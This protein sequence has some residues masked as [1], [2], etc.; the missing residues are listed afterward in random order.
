V[1]DPY[2]DGIELHWSD[3]ELLETCQV[4]HGSSWR[5]QEGGQEQA[6]SADRLGGGDV[7]AQR[8]RAWCP[9]CDAEVTAG[10]CSA[11]G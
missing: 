9:E 8:A 3:L 11:G 10:A 2:F 6:R 1:F 5:T 4:P 7:P